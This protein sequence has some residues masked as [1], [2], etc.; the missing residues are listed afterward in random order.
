MRPPVSRA[1][2]A[3]V[4]FGRRASPVAARCASSSAASPAA[5]A[6]VTAAYGEAKTQDNLHASP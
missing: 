6:A 5:A 3:S 4:L 1:A 2:F